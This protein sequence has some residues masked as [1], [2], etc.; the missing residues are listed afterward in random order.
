[1]LSGD[2]AGSETCLAGVRTGTREDYSDH[3]HSAPEDQLAGYDAEQFQSDI[4]GLTVTDLEHLSTRKTTPTW[5]EAGVPTSSAPETEHSARAH[6]VRRAAD[7][8]AQEG[9][10]SPGAGFARLQFE[11]PEYWCVLPRTRAA[12]DYRADHNQK[13]SGRIPVARAQL[14]RVPRKLAVRT[15]TGGR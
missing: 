7:S 5:C 3:D 9:N 15:V 14:A 13:Q 12:N 2:L 4:F 10:G 11:Q 1:M 8:A 6:D